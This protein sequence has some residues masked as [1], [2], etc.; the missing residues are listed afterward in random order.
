MDNSRTVETL[1]RSHHANMV[2]DGFK[3]FNLFPSSNEIALSR[4]SPFFLMDYGAPTYFPPTRN[5]RGVEEHPHRGFETVTIAFQGAVAHRDSGGNSGVI[6]PGDVQWMTAAGGVVH[7]EKH[8]PAFAAEGGTLEMLQL[9]VNLPKAHKMD[10]PS[11]Q[12]IT[13]ADIPEV[14]IGEDG[15]TLRVIAGSYGDAKGPASTHTPLHM[16]HIE[17]K[18]G[19]MIQLDLPAHYNTGVLLK[20]GTATIGDEMVHAIAFAVMKNEEGT[21]D[22]VAIEDSSLIVLSGEPINEPIVAYGPFVMNTPEE[23]NEA[24]ADYRSGKMG[25]L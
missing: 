20:K 17:L 19:D 7:E 9:W 14:A 23:I 25:H 6:Y 16:Y 8:E 13:K 4:M 10:T 21:T 2:G 24:L 12:G 11:Y 22:I 15:S 18:A 5:P 3:V 1:I